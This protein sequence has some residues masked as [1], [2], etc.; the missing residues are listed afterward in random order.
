MEESKVYLLR[1]DLL[2]RRSFLAASLG[3]RLLLGIFF[4]VL[5]INDRLLYDVSAF[6]TSASSDGYLG[7]RGTS[8]GTTSG[9][10]RRLTICVIFDCSLLNEGKPTIMAIENKCHLSARLPCCGLLRLL[11]LVCFGLITIFVLDLRLLGR[12]VSRSACVL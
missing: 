3:L 10:L 8:R 7:A 1:R 11:A 2:R 12:V 4:V 9:L 6:E 5:I